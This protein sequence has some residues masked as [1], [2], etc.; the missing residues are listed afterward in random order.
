MR[1]ASK[2]LYLV[3]MILSFVGVALWAIIGLVL[4]I[5]GIAAAASGSGDEATAAAAAGVGSSIF[6][7]IAAVLCLVLAI[8]S[9]RARAGR[10]SNKVALVFGIIGMVAYGFGGPL[11][12]GAILGMVADNQGQPA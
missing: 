7:I 2:I 6:M 8:V 12:V 5:G 11:L 1:K 4:L 9:L 3:S 10:V